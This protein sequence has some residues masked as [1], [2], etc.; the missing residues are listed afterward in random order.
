MR[1]SFCSRLL[2]QISRAWPLELHKGSFWRRRVSIFY[3][4]G[5]HSQEFPY[6]CGTTIAEMQSALLQLK[7]YFRFVTL[8]EV[9]SSNTVESAVPIAALTFDDGLDLF[10]NGVRYLIRE[11]EIPCTLFLV[12]NCVGNT[13]IMWYHRLRLV[14]AVKGQARMLR[15]INGG[16][17]EPNGYSS[18]RSIDGLPAATKKWPPTRKDEFVDLIWHLCQMPPMSAYLAHKPYLEWTDIDAWIS[19]GHSIGLHTASHPFCSQLDNADIETEIVMPALELMR[20]AGYTRIALAYPFGDRPSQRV[21][22]DLADSGL[23][24]CLLGICG[25]SVRGCSPY[26]LERMSLEGGVDDGIFG[27][28]LIRAAYKNVPKRER[29]HI[30]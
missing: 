5:V 9:L 18:V 8:N 19:D 1:R 12:T 14:A 7:A 21:E 2:G 30:V 23:F 29:L 6:V 3:L 24:S 11:L 26:Q 20:H 17:Q 22:E 15:A 27:R 16:I 13:T 28:A 25:P 4:H 10:R